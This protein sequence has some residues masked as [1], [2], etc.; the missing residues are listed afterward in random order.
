MLA[1]WA[2]ATALANGF[3]EDDEEKDW[4]VEFRKWAAD[5]FG[6]EFGEAVSHGA[7]R[8]ALG[9]DI[10][11]RIGQ[12]D[13]FIRAPKREQEGRD[14]YHA[15]VQA[16]AGPVAGYALN[17][18]LGGADI[19]K[20][21][22]DLDGGKFMRGVET[23]VPAFIKNPLTAARYEAED[24]LRT[25]DG[26]KQI[27]LTAFD[28]AGQA[29]GF[30]PTRVAEMYD[31]LNAVKNAEHRITERRKELIQM[32]VRALQERDSEKAGEALDEIKAFN[33]RNPTMAIKGDTILRSLQN[34]GKREQGTKDGIYLQKNREFLRAEGAFANVN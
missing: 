6:K 28:K 12:N 33:A 5:T 25:R 21:T 15:W 14:A 3:G 26:Q 16:L 30:T 9:W 10:A 27:D 4:E 20:G 8:L 34:R 32:R 7:P 17:G 2:L 18:Y 11:G 29:L 13:L 22:K 24:G 19:I 31:G 1:E 23:M